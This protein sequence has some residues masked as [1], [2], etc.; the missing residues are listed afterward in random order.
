MQR[1]HKGQVNCRYCAMSRRCLRAGRW[2]SVM[3]LALPAVLG[4]W[5][6]H[7]GSWQYSGPYANLTH[8]DLCCGRWRQYDARVDVGMLN[9]CYFS[10]Y[11]DVCESAFLKNT[12]Q[13]FSGYGRVAVWCFWFEAGGLSRCWASGN[14]ATLMQLLA[15]PNFDGSL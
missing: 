5:R 8:S 10:R 7:Y 9:Y 1:G 14:P 11:A 12:R 4:V 15:P 6:Y 13:R 3:F 2:R